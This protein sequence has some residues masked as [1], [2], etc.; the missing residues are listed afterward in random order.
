MA[1]SVCVPCGAAPWPPHETATAAAAGLG[2]RARS[3]HP[4]LCLGPPR[5]HVSFGMATVSACFETR[6][7]G[8]RPVGT[9]QFYG[10]V[11]KRPSRRCFCGKKKKGEASF[12]K[13]TKPLEMYF[14]C[15]AMYTKP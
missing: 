2:V 14:I 7:S 8:G 15:Q 13:K 4:S 5:R 3:E 11:I 9:L 1:A 12:V 10:N 6:A